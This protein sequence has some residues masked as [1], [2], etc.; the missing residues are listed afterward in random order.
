[1]AD[2]APEPEVAAKTSKLPKR[3]LIIDTKLVD[4]DYT[5]CALP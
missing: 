2:A 1:M 3:L 5:L 4:D